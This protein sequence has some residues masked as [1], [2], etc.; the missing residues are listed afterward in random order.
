MSESSIGAATA[1]GL[2]RVEAIK[3]HFNEPP[4]L[5][6]SRIQESVAAIRDLFDDQESR[7]VII[8]D[9]PD[10][11]KRHLLDLNGV[12]VDIL[13]IDGNSELAIIIPSRP[14]DEGDDV[15]KGKLEEWAARD[16]VH[17]HLLI[18]NPTEVKKGTPEALYKIASST[19]EQEEKRFNDIEAKARNFFAGNSVVV[20]AGGLGIVSGFANLKATAELSILLKPWIGGICMVAAILGVI[21]SVLLHLVQR[22][23]DWDGRPRPKEF[24]DQYHCHGLDHVYLEAANALGKSYRSLSELNDESVCLLE[25]GIGLSLLSLALFFVSLLMLM[26]SVFF[27]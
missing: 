4:P 13:V 5:R 26:L 21:A 2:L 25:Y 24:I 1:R 17:L 9:L 7:P 19:V 15:R 14:P 11:P 23:K 18:D 16:P 3:T 6:V 27:S 12:R 22:A 20:G 8:A 10:Y